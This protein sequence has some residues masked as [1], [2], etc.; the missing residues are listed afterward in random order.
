MT[1]GERES[2]KTMRSH[3]IHLEHMA[4]TCHT[5]TVILSKKTAGGE[6]LLNV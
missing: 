1:K 2:N 5:L 6:I 3:I 4:T